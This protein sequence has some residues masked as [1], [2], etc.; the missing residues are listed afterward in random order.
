[1]WWSR[2]LLAGLAALW[3]AGCGF[4]P[5]YG[6]RSVG[7]PVAT[8]LASIDIKPIADHLGQMMRNSLTDRLGAGAAARPRYALEVGI[9]SSHFDRAFQQNSL[10][11][12]SEVN[13]QAHFRLLDGTT[14][15]FK[16]TA[17]TSLSYDLLN[18]RYAAT[19]AQRDTD[20]RA[21]DVLAEDIRTQLALFFQRQ[22]AP[23]PKP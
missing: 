14:E 18:E 5:V 21:A 8:E 4:Q 3:L 7:A 15:L 23:A 13:Y 20:S 22:K 17:K 16:G 19:Q 11:T 1:M 12:R 10:A 2:P 6:E 9:K